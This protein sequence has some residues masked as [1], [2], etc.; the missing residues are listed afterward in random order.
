MMCCVKMCNLDAYVSYISQVQL[1][2]NTTN[3]NYVNNINNDSLSLK[4]YKQP[5]ERNEENNLKGKLL[6]CPFTKVKNTCRT[7]IENKLPID[8]TAI[9][10]KRPRPL[11]KE[12][13]KWRSSNSKVGQRSIRNTTCL[14]VYLTD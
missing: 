11:D 2:Q 9:E 4:F 12:T 10:I 8:S 6:L 13:Y 5:F 14:S 1:F 7:F 3:A